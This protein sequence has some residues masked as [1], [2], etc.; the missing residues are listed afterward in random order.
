MLEQLE[1]TKKVVVLAAVMTQGK[2]RTYWIV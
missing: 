1:R 2:K